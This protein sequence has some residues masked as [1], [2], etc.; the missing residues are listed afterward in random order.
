MVT[1]GIKV[2][3]SGYN[4]GTAADQNLL[5]TTALPNYK[6]AASGTFGVTIPV[7]SVTATTNIPHNLGYSPTTVL[8]CQY[9]L[10][11]NYRRVNGFSNSLDDIDLNVVNGTAN[12]SVQ[13]FVVDP[14]A[15]GQTFSGYYY[16]FYDPNNA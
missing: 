9:N 2:S 11:G 14:S 6:V 13:A 12:I 16:I 3:N 10:G 15:E 7:G 1:Y 4:V 5:L 8:M